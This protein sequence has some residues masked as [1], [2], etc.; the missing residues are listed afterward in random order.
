MSAEGETAHAHVQKGLFGWFWRNDLRRHLPTI[1]V[2]GLLMSVEGAMLGVLS[3]LMR[4]MFDRVFV[5]GDAAALVPV[6]LAIAAVFGVRALAGVAQKLLI[7]RV[8]ARITLDM[9]TRLLRH[10]M[11]LDT[12]FHSTNPPGALMERIS[13]DTNAVRSVGTTLVTGVGRDAVSLVSLI[14]VVLWIDWRWTLI[15]LVGTPLLVFPSIV[16]QRFVRRIT[17]ANRIVAGQMATRLNEIF[18]GI[19]PIKLNR[20]EQYQAGRFHDLADQR[21]HTEVQAALGKALIPAMVDIMSGIGFLAVLVYGGSEII[22]GDKTVGEFMS[23]F[24]AMALAFE[25]LRRLGALSG[26]WQTT[27]VSLDRLKTLFDTHPTLTSPARPLP[28]SQAAG[29][30]VFDDVHLAYGDLPVLRGASLTAEAGRTTALVGASGAGKS[31]LFNV[32]ARLVEI[33]RGRVTL[34]GSD[35]AAF[36]LG[37]LRG[38][39][40][41]VTQDALLFDET[42]RENILLGR[43]DV[44]EAQLGAVLQAAHVADF[45]RELPLGLETPAGPRGSSLSGGQRQRVAIARALLRDT[46]IL[47]LDE[48]TSALDAQSEALVQQALDRLSQGRTT[49][50][51]AHRLATIRKADRIIVLDQ[52]RVVEQGTHETLLAQDGVYARLCALQFAQAD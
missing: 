50:V 42:I 21:L 31:T 37:D 48:A 49:L 43:T 6:G 34:G 11:T 45:L 51:I 23:F 46:P 40:S 8:A 47:L 20:L 12:L 2:A 52:G 14:A 13:G 32:L 3:Y 19:N 1:V 33:D 5:G 17:R 22:S 35:I 41:V 9:Q 18:H 4:P 30:I 28:L 29:D 15:A 16:V 36:A 38:Q 10:L 44:P 7:A 25:P 39:I 27:A 24:A 26:L